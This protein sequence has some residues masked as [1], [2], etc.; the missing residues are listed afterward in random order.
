MPIRSA[1][2]FLDS[3]NSVLNDISEKLMRLQH[4]NALL[5][6]LLPPELADH[7]QATE[8][9]KGCLTLTATDNSFGMLLRYQTQNILSGLR[10]NPVFAGLT[11]I[12]TKVRPVEALPAETKKE[13]APKLNPMTLSLESSQS[14]LEY[15]KNIDDKDIREALEKLAQNYQKDV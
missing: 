10:K 3:D 11:S 9:D 8:L 13:R 15:A 2:Y 14:L 12:K 6:D 4:I 1:N 7:C 5:K